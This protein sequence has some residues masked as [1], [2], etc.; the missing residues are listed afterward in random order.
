MQHKAIIYKISTTA[1]LDL[2][3]SVSWK[4]IRPFYQIKLSNIRWF[5]LI[6][7]HFYHT[8]SQSLLSFYMIYLLT[9][10]CIEIYFS[11]QL[12][13]YSQKLSLDKQDHSKSLSEWWVLYN[14]LMPYRFSL[15]KLSL[16][17]IPKLE[18]L[19]RKWK[20]PSTSHLWSSSESGWEFN[21][22]RNV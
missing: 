2:L 16:Y 5:L 11:T 9:C 17:W 7:F 21:H 6:L 15:V 19:Q 22:C 8:Q 13:T 20:S 3:F 14:N 10:I 18:S 1:N 12:W 4:V